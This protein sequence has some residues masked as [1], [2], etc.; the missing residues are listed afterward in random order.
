MNLVLVSLFLVFGIGKTH[1][2][3]VKELGHDGKGQSIFS[4]SRREESQS[5]KAYLSDSGKSGYSKREFSFSL[6][7]FAL[8]MMRERKNE[9]TSPVPLFPSH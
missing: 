5:F 3:K 9:L 6:P 7:R 8:P 2:S 1:T 4:D